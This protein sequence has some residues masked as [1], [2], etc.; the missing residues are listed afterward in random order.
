MSDFQPIPAPEQAPAGQNPSPAPKKD[1]SWLRTAGLAVAAA[2]IGYG[3][4]GGAPA[5]PEAQVVTETVE[6][7]VEVPVEVPVEKIVEKRVEVASPAC[8]EAL[9]LAAEGFGIAAN[10]VGL[11]EPAARAG[12]DQDVDAINSI[13]GKMEVNGQ[14]L[15]ELTPAAAAASEKCRATSAGGV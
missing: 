12:L 1:R 4:A 15:S 8:L 11:I 7:R 5:A 10:Y 13:I 3:A 9:D 14:L 2:V 6:K